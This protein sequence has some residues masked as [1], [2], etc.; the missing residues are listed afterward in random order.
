M[1]EDEV[2]FNGGKKVDILSLV[3]FLKDEEET[4]VTLAEP[5]RGDLTYSSEGEVF[6]AG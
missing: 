6:N 5:T 2:D 4:A 3:G 1:T